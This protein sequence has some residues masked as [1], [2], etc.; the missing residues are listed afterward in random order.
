MLTPAAGIS[1]QTPTF[2]SE[3]HHQPLCLLDPLGRF[4]DLTMLG[5]FPDHPLHG[6][7]VVIVFSILPLCPHNTPVCWFNLGFCE[8]HIA[9][10]LKQNPYL[11]CLNTPLIHHMCAV[12]I[13]PLYILRHAYTTNY[14]FI[15]Y[16]LVV[17]TL[18]K[19]LVSRE[20]LSHILWKNKIHVPNHQ[21]DMEL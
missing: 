7:V 14:K 17:S 2:L 11:C 15:I 6:D 13:S 10:S 21:P 3:I 5:W 18:W 8:Q 4:C 16:W 1:L 20:G 12:W 19:I 9:T